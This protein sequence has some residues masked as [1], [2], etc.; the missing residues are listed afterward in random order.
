MYH[1]FKKWV[2]V[3]NLRKVWVELLKSQR[4]LLDL[5]CVQLDGSQTI[6]KNGGNAISYQN[7]CNSF[8]LA[9]NQGLMLACSC[10]VAGQDHDLF[11]L[12]IKQVF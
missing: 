11:L 3:G 12:Q 2:S 4:K 7:S 1:Y 10:Q 8:F 6:C 5:F 9:D